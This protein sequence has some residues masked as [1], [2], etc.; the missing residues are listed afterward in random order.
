MYLLSEYYKKVIDV[1]ITFYVVYGRIK[2]M[3]YCS[4]NVYTFSQKQQQK[5]DD[6]ICF[7]DIEVQLPIAHESLAV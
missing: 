4:D 7:L 5:H 3:D 1:V 2:N 6:S